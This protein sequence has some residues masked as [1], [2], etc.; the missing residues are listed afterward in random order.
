MLHHGQPFIQAPTEW[1]FYNFNV[2]ELAGSTARFAIQCVSTDAFMLMIDDFRIDS[3]DDGVDNENVEIIPQMNVL[4]QNYPNPFN[5]ETSISFDIKEAGKVS[6]DI[7]NVKGQKVKTLLNDHREAGTHNI[8][9]NGTDDNNR[10][11]S[12]GIYFYKMKNGKFSSTKKMILM[13]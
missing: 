4:N 3:T 11:V 2:S 7:Y 9:W 12:S 13:K 5:P 6:L 10:S 8:V 1:T